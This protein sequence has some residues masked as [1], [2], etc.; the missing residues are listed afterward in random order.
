[1]VGVSAS[2]NL[3]LHHKI[4]RFSSG[5]GSPGRRMFVVVVVPVL[6]G[7][8]TA[9]NYYPVVV[10]LCLL[11]HISRCQHASRQPASERGCYGS[12]NYRNVIYPDISHS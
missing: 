8:E 11:Q 10:L 9:G 12:K 1:M 5:T 2:V 3:P 4:Q 7:S 6:L